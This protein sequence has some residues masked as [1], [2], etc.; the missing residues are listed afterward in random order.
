[1]TFRNVASSIDCC[2]VS[3]CPWMYARCAIVSLSLLAL[4]LPAAES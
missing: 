1:M 3:I 4:D 2:N